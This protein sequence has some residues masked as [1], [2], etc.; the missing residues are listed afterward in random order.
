MKS[1]NEVKIPVTTE[2][3]DEVYNKLYILGF[4]TIL[5]E[6]NYLIVYVEDTRSEEI[7]NLKSG[8]DGLINPDSIQIK[9]FEDRNW[10]REWET[11]I[12]PVYIR[13]KIAIFP[14][15]Q[16]ENVKDVEIKIEIDPKM[17][18][19]TGHNETTQLVLE[20]MC[21]FIDKDDKYM[22]DFGSGTGVLTI[23]GI[24]M[25]MEKAIAI[26]TD[27]DAIE[28]SIEYFR[29]NGVSEN[30]YLHR[31]NIKDISEEKFDVI[32]ANIIRSVIENNIRY[33]YEKLKP[34]G[35]IFISGVLVSETE[36]VLEV[37]SAS[38]FSVKEVYKKAEW[39]GI[40]ARKE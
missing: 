1:Y 8:L 7:D 2:L 30:V 36:R 6:E 26:D 31:K 4:D 9:K 21:D 15:W 40:Y 32:C 27:N 13:E 17:S 24:K 33:I 12:E 39:L 3:T 37:L 25:G 16:K 20:L 11:N 38:G 34:G 35:K 5:E 23:A 19:G 22:L 10:N 28:N 29:I 14:S 18:F